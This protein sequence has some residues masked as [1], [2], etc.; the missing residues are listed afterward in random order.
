MRELREV[1]LTHLISE[2]GIALREK[3]NKYL[4]RVATDANKLEIK[5]AVEQLF[6]VEVTDVATMVMRGKTKRYGF[7]RQEGRRPNWKKAVVKLQA[8]QKIEAFET[9]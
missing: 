4:F 8:G 9:L 3:Q 2:K 7:R 6:K 1:I 5:R